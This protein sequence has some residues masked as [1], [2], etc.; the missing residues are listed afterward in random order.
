MIVYKLRKYFLNKDCYLYNTS[1]YYF[2]VAQTSDSAKGVGLSKVSHWTA[3][4]FQKG[5]GG[6]VICRLYIGNRPL[7]VNFWYWLLLSTISQSW[8]TYNPDLEYISK[9]CISYL[10]L[11][12][13][14][15]ITTVTLIKNNHYVRM[16]KHP[17]F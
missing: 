11:K 10:I 12:I 8:N 5:L 13:L 3:S 15:K 6:R 7:H 14:E 16:Q 9:I 17:F 4:Y 2:S 1:F